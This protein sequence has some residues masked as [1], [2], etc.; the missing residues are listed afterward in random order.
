MEIMIQPSD[1]TNLVKRLNFEVQEQIIASISETVGPP[2]VLIWNQPGQEDRFEIV[3]ATKKI[4]VLSVVVP[5]LRIDENRRSIPL[6]GAQVE[7]RAAWRLDPNGPWLR[8]E[9]FGEAG[10]LVMSLPSFEPE[11]IKT[12]AATLAE[13]IGK[14]LDVQLETC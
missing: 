9:V 5:V 3:C 7:A 2:Y 1:L 12:A 10:S 6:S 13:T 8:N 4:E 14:Y 11:H